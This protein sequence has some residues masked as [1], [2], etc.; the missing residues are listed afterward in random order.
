[1]ELEKYPRFYFLKEQKPL[2]LRLL[3]ELTYVIEARFD[4]SL[5]QLTS[6][7]KEDDKYDTMR[8]AE[9]DIFDYIWMPII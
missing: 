3:Q 4:I 9:P 1:M 7:I 5:E 8:V 6:M 2:F